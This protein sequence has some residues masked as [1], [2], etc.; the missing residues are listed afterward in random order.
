MTAPSRLRVRLKGLQ[1]SDCPPGDPSINL[2]WIF[3]DA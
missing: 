1:P 2:D 3:D